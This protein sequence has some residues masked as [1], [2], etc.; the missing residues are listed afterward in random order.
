MQD[1][2]EQLI[3]PAEA[4]IRHAGCGGLN[5]RELLIG[6]GGLLM[7]LLLIGTVAIARMGYLKG[8]VLTHYPAQ[9][10]QRVD[11]EYAPKYAVPPRVHPV[12]PGKAL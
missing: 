1:P 7:A 10:G 4:H 9:F 8:L 5:F 6:A 2:A 11:G 12:L 3:S